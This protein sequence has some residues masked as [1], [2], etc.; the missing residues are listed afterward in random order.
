MFTETIIIKENLNLIIKI[1]FTLIKDGTA[2]EKKR[3]LTIWCYRTRN[4]TVLEK[5]KKKK[6]VKSEVSK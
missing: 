5:K 1:I 2:R 4:K 6:K 3:H